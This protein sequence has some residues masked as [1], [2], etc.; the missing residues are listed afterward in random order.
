MIDKTKLD[1]QSVNRMNRIGQNSQVTVH[2]L[3]TKD[4]T[5]KTRSKT[6]SRTMIRPQTQAER[7]ISMCTGCKYETQNCNPF[8]DIKCPDDAYII[9][10]DVE[11]NQM[12]KRLELLEQSLKERKWEE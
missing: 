5:D 1:P 3:T 6:M 4:S 8:T 12:A 2:D 7:N 11:F 9:V 10:D